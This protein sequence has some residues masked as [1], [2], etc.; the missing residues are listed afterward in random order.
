LRWYFSSKRQSYELHG[1]VSQK[2]ATSITAS[3]R[4]S[5]HLII[6]ISERECHRLD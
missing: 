6:L 3:V 5:D 1:G 4:T 2:M